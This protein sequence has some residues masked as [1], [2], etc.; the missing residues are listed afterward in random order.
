MLSSA[1]KCKSFKANESAPCAAWHTQNRSE[2]N[3]NDVER[4]TIKFSQSICMADFHSYSNT[5]TLI[6]V[7]DE[8]VFMSSLCIN[9]D[10]VEWK[11]KKTM[12]ISCQLL[13][14]LALDARRRWKQF[15][16]RKYIFFILLKWENVSNVSHVTYSIRLKTQVG[17]D[18]N[19]TTLSWWTWKIKTSTRNSWGD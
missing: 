5:S 19:W 16:S 8:N 9:L 12:K 10:R 18:Q 13:S 3:V 17:R 14:T 11:K 4:E 6:V 1:C 2:Y 15:S 7:S